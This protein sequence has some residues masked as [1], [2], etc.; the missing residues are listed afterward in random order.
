MQG[1][2]INI[3]T[4]DNL[5]KKAQSRKLATVEIDESSGTLKYEL[6]I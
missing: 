1:L 2:K 6:H 3:Q 4:I 5:L